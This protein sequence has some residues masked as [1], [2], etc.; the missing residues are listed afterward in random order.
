MKPEFPKRLSADQMRASLEAALAHWNGRT[1]LWVFAYGSLIW[2]PEVDF[3]CRAPARIYG[4]H[5]SLCLRS[6]RNRGTPE[7]PGLVAGLD[8]GGSCA[9]IV[10]RVPAAAVHAQFERLWEREM[11]LGSYHARWLPCHRLDRDRVVRAMAFVVRRK[12]PNYCGQLPDQE[13][14]RSLR[15][16]HGTYGSSREY[17]QRIVEG[18]QADGLGDP[19]LERLARLAAES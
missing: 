14:V 7:Q 19:K 3:D 4:Y 9:G 1:P 17:L 16:A 13:I 6:I 11:F 15:F 5:R 10:Y 18:L 2:N 12:A 8:R